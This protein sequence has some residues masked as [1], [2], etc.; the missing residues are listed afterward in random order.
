MLSF[1]K[2]KLTT[3]L[4]REA[5]K[6]NGQTFV[7]PWTHQQKKRERLAFRAKLKGL[8]E[9]LRRVRELGHRRPAFGIGGNIGISFPLL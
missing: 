5:A 9:G 7:W 4:E 8:F 3:S 6:N 1:A 2:P